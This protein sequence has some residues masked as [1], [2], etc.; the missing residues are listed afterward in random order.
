MAS[1]GPSGVRRAAGGGAAERECK[2]RA[3][4]EERLNVAAP[5][6]ASRCRS[7]LVLVLIVEEDK[8][9]R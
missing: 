7:E 6:A 5:A 4:L 1:E 8:A 9:R 3:V 2:A